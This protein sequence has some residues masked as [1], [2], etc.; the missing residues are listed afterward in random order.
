MRKGYLLSGAVAAGVVLVLMVASLSFL[1]RGIGTSVAP[2][3]TSPAT[4]TV[5]PTSVPN[6]TFSPSARP[7]R[8]SSVQG[9]APAP[10]PPPAA[11]LPAPTP[12]LPDV[13]VGSAA[14]VASR[15]G[16]GDDQQQKCRAH[17]A[18]LGI[19]TTDTSAPCIELGDV[20]ANLKRGTFQFNKPNTAILEEAFPLRLVLLTG[21]GQSGDFKGLPGQVET[22]SDRPFAQSV[23]ATLTGDDF[24]ISPPGAQARTATLTQP[25]EWDWKVKPTSSGTKSITIDVAAIIQIGSD[26]NRVQITTLHESIEI[27]V[28][29]FQR[30][31]S[32]VA[33][34]S[35]TAAAITGLITALAGVIGFV[36][37]IREFFKEYVLVVFRPRRDGA[38]P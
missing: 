32:Y 27:Q 11:V 2:I 1:G 34:V 3:S 12:L 28:T 20:V 10:P 23:E 7:L 36:P 5:A 21:E 13:R 33:S 31:K 19:V 22:R 37:K 18:S 24:E 14:I 26:K 9:V 29:V 15:P 6:S 17:N 38:P 35:G 25:V 8:P 16:I 4:P 30:L